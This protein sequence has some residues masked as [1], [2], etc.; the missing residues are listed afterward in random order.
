MTEPSPR[1]KALLDN[2]RRTSERDDQ[3]SDDV[4]ARL[5]A[6]IA[7]PP[8]EARPRRAAAI[9]ALGGTLAAA[10]AVAAWGWTGPDASQT[11][12][13]QPVSSALDDMVDRAP[14]GR[15]VTPPPAPRPSVPTPTPPG[16]VPPP[17]PARPP[18]PAPVPKTLR[19]PED[20]LARELGV[21]RQARRAIREGRT[22]DAKATLRAHALA[23]PDGQLAEERDALLVVVLC[24]L[25]ESP[26][27]RTAFEAAHPG[28]HHATAIATA[29]EKTSPAVTD[30]RGNGQ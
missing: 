25:G 17:A 11:V 6:A 13:P 20:A 5:A 29:C 27:G 8:V 19:E 14:R 24:T 21:L 28:S 16:S 9:W 15:T 3:P 7:A 18:K 10:S 2:Y 12:R 22:A 1:A 26:T 30:R 4:R 23:H